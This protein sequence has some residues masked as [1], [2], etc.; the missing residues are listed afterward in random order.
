MFREF[1]FERS[2]IFALLPA[3]VS[4]MHVEQSIER[5]GGFARRFYVASIDPIASLRSA[6]FFVLASTVSDFPA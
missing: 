5:Y 1:L 2:N 3:L 4:K 6:S